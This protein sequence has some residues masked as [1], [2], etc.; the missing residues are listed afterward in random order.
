MFVERGEEGEM[1]LVLP[2]IL[3]LVLLLLLLLILV[4]ILDRFELIFF[5]LSIPSG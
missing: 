3:L 5:F 1:V 2:R 4:L